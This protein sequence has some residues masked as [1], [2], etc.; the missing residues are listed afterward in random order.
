MTRAER[1]PVGQ[2]VL[3]HMVTLVVVLVGLNAHHLSRNDTENAEQ[4]RAPA[5]NASV[6]AAPFTHG[7]LHDRPRRA[8]AAWQVLTT[9]TPETWWGVFW[10]AAAAHTMPGWSLIGDIGGAGAAVTT[11]GPPSTRAPP[12]A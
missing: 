2:H 8:V 3:L 5:N 7:V 12:A 10:P 9:A 6:S 1:P 4:Y 11:S